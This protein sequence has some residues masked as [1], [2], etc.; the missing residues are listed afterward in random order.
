MYEEM[1]WDKIPHTKGNRMALPDQY[2]SESIFCG[3][4]DQVHGVVGVVRGTLPKRLSEM[5]RV[6]LYSDFVTLD[7]VQTLDG[8]V[9]TINALEVQRKYRW[10]YSILNLPQ[11]SVSYILM[12]NMILELWTMGAEVILLSAID[13]PGS[14]LMRRLGFKTFNRPHIF[15]PRDY[16][17]DKDA[18]ILRVFDMAIITRDFRVGHTAGPRL[19]NPVDLAAPLARLR[20]YL[21]EANKIPACS[22]VS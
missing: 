2:D 14:S 8:K 22:S 12:K 17:T 9:G 11:A 13:G 10:G 15:L 6:K 20:I 3:T 18:P 21:N 7:F 19:P 4:V 5:Y 16:S 1:C